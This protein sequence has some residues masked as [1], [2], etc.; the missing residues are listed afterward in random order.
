MLDSAQPLE[1]YKGSDRV[2]VMLNGQVI[3][4]LVQ[5]QVKAVPPPTPLLVHYVLAAW[6][7]FQFGA[8]P[9]DALSNN[10]FPLR[11]HFGNNAEET[12]YTYKSRP[13]G[14]I[15]ETIIE[16]EHC[17]AKP[18]IRLTFKKAVAPPQEV[19]DELVKLGVEVVIDHAAV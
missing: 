11:F 1:I 15:T 16:F 4:N 18:I 7:T 5:F 10:A 6:P 19:L 9:D 8:P 3:T 14:G 17:A 13:F 2:L 12:I